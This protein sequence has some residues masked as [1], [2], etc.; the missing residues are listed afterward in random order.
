MQFYYD[1]KMP[2]RI[3]DEGEFWKHQE[4]EHTVVI[5]QLVKNLEPAFVTSL[6][7]WEL[8]LK[9]TQGLFVRYIEAVARSGKHVSPSLLREIK[10][11]VEFALH[12]SEQFVKL[13]NQLE[14]ESNAIKT[15]PTA[16][17]VVDHIRRESEYFMGI[18][19]ALLSKGM[20]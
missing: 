20:L 16:K 11:L 4:S 1:E 18:T 15:N 14:A 19:E 12:Q 7:K 13:L 3:L 8:A 5:R 9:K 10:S 6:E 2:L 17:T